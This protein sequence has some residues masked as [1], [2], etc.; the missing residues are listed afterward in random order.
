MQGIGAT[1]SSTGQAVEIS[2]DDGGRLSAHTP[3]G[4]L[5]QTQPVTPRRLKLRGDTLKW[6]R[7][8]YVVDDVAAAREFVDSLGKPPKPYRKIA[9]LTGIFTLGLALGVLG[10]VIL[11]DRTRDATCDEA[12]EVVAR[13][14]ENMEELNQAET[15]DQSFFAAVIVEQRAV[16]YAMDAASSCFSLDE[17]AAAEGLLEGIRGLLMSSGG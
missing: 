17:R 3:D 9:L 10:G 6:S 2:V 8:E 15:Q 12:E 11:R 1:R 7:V 13:S 14:V 4:I 16:T 5:L